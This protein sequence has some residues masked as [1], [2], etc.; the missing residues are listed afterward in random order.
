MNSCYTERDKSR[1]PCR[2]FLSKI[3]GAGTYAST[4]SVNILLAVPN[5]VPTSVKLLKIFEVPISG[6]LLWLSQYMGT[7][8]SV[9]SLG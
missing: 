6:T 5:A 2:A 7:L 1:V 4:C 8:N 3:T 9:L